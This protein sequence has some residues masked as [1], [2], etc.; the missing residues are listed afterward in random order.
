MLSPN[1]TLAWL[2][3]A[4][5]ALTATRVGAQSYPNEGQSF[6]PQDLQD[7]Q[8]FAPV[9][10]NSYDAAVEPHQGFFFTYDGLVWAIKSPPTASIG[11]APPNNRLV[12]Y[13]TDA[14]YDYQYS[15]G[16]TSPL[17]TQYRY[18]N[19]FE[20]G[21]MGRDHGIYGCYFGLAQLNQ[22]YGL[23][24]VDMVIKD[25]VYG[26]YGESRLQGLVT[27]NANMP[28]NLFPDQPNPAYLT[29]TTYVLRNLPLTFTWM[30]VQNKVET[31]GTELMYVRR[32]RQCSRWFGCGRFEM[33]LGA[34]YLDF[35]D[36]FTVKGYGGILDSSYWNTEAF[37][38]IIGPE[39]G[40][41]MWWTR[42]R[43]TL[44]TDARFTAGFNHQNFRTQ[45]RLGENLRPT[46]TLA[47]TGL[48]YSLGPTGFT[49]SETANEFAPII[50]GRLNLKYQLTR[51]VSLKVGGTMI[52][53]DGVARACNSLYY[54]MPAFEIDTI[55]NQESVWMAGVN[56]GIEVNR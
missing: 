38:R 18:G 52:W 16:D 36:T 50:E 42:G 7:M 51:N 4:A 6:P 15:E 12:F 26:A 3:A 28:T 27:H 41:R 8:P 30:D 47:V 24:D 46:G 14:A 1:R 37:N 49:D 40:G 44:E 53:I 56:V 34:R 45:G 43:W 20:Y 33:M 32:F 35:E 13:G 5:L 48:P 19:R 55:N 23:S 17:S 29:N 22:E 25:P 10:V 9:D 11:L 31:W 54:T 39:I 21:Y 2:V